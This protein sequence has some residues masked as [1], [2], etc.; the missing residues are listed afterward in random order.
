MTISGTLN[1]EANSITI[2][3][4]TA[5]ALCLLPDRVTPT[6]STTLDLRSTYNC[7]GWD[8]PSVR[9]ANSMKALL[10]RSVIPIEG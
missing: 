10:D 6:H 5:M 4:P 7:L 9:W 8:F 3:N 2:R 1:A